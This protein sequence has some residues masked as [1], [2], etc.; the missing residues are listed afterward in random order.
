MR[1]DSAACWLPSEKGGEQWFLRHLTLLMFKNAD[2]HADWQIIK[3][4]AEQTV[5]VKIVS[6]KGGISL[7]C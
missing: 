4:A 1:I 3:I 7:F 5:P 6:N 2:V